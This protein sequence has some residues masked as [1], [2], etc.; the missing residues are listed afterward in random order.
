[1]VST[2][3]FGLLKIFGGGSYY[4]NGNLNYFTLNASF[5]KFFLNRY[6]FNYILAKRFNP[7]IC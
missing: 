6:M 5:N 1:M 7:K 4:N 2:D 3:D